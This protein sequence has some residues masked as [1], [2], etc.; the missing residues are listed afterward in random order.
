M[1]ITVALFPKRK[2]RKCSLI[3]M[4]KRA[5]IRVRDRGLFLVATKS[6]YKSFEI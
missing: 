3:F 5:A 2:E 1:K 6:P 4:M